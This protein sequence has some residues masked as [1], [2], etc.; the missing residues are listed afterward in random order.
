[1]HNRCKV[2]TS[3]VGEIFQTKIKVGINPFPKGNYLIS[4]VHKL[5]THFFN[6]SERYEHMWKLASV[7]SGTHGE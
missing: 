6:G 3:A 5:V 4:K 7:L 2:G 1:M